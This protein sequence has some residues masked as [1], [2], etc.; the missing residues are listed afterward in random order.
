[1]GVLGC[2]WWQPISFSV[3]SSLNKD[4]HLNIIR[5]IAV[6]LYVKPPV[7]CVCVIL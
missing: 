6:L 7:C 3:L 4:G 5:K 2:S 1:M